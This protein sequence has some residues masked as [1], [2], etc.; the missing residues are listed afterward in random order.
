MQ[1]ICI[2]PISNCLFNI[3]SSGTMS[4][5]RAKAI[6]LLVLPTMTEMSKDDLVKWSAMLDI[7]HD[8]NATKL[9]L[10]EMIQQKLGYVKE[11]SHK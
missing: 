11:P 8:A 5:V 6:E 9:Q 7:A 1:Y 2:L 10:A 4:T 3:A